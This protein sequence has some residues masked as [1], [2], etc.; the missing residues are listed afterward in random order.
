[1][2]GDPPCPR[3]A[4]ISLLIAGASSRASN[5]PQEVI[6]HLC[7]SL[8]AKAS[9]LPMQIHPTCGEARATS[10]STS[11]PLGNAPY[12][13]PPPTRRPAMNPSLTL[14]LPASSSN[15]ACRPTAIFS[16]N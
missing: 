13:R 4:G 11:T 10:A 3:Q 5:L 12:T 16:V 15:L 6:V 14:E 9:D 2:G 1:M 8:L 7:A